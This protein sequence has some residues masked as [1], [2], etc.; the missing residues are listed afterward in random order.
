MKI[1]VCSDA[2]YPVNEFVVE[3]LERL[4][5]QVVL[6]GAI[7]TGQSEPWI[8]TAHVAAEA[9]RKGECDE[10]IFLLDW[11]RHFDRGE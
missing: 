8:K 10:G 9:I 1:A 2:L 3:E 6:F 11:Y 7:K 5:H 4:G